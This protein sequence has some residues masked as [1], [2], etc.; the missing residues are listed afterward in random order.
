[1]VIHEP[2]FTMAVVPN[3][4]ELKAH[5]RLAWLHRLLWRALHRMGALKSGM[6]EQ[7]TFKT[8]TIQPGRVLD[9]LHKAVPALGRSRR[10]W[11]KRLLIGPDEMAEVMNDSSFRDFAQLSAGPRFEVMGLQVE[12]VPHMKGVLVL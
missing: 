3:H 12:V 11:P 9:Q 6:A 2:R 4:Y 10:D 5:G 1:M 8:V 7:A